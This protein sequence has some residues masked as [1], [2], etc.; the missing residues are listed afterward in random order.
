MFPCVPPPR[1]VSDE[2]ETLDSATEEK[3][4]PKA[5]AIAF[6]APVFAKKQQAEIA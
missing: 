4:K 1:L 2:L 6:P 3:K 5:A